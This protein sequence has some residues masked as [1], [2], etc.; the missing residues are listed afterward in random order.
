MTLSDGV[1]TKTYT[2]DGAYTEIQLK[3]VVDGAWIGDETGNNVTFNLT[4]AGDFT[5]YCDGQKTWVDGDIVAYDDTL[6]IESVTAVGNGAEDGSNWLNNITWDPAAEA[7]HMYEQADGVY[8]ISFT[9]GEYD[10]SDPEFKFA[11]NDAW[12]HN[13]GLADNGAVENGV[14]T[15]AIYNGST[16]IKIEGLSEGTMIEAILDLSDFDFTTKTGAKMTISW[17]VP[18]EPDYIIGDF[19]GDGEVTSADAT[20][21]Q[22]YDA[23]FPMPNDIN[24]NY[25]AADVDGDGQITIIDATCIQRYLA[26]IGNYTK[27]GIGEPGYYEA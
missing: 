26:K 6:D 23:H 2:V 7:N 14:E 25:A 4:G 13:F 15:D 16:N 27:W 10:T 9:L 8:I 22:R 5:V 3:A 20:W 24:F 12:T 18:A 19:D 17:G 1:Y 11:I 21:I